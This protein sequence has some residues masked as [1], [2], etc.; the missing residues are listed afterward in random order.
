LLIIKRIE[1]SDTANPKFLAQTDLTRKDYNVLPW[2]NIAMAA[3]NA[4]QVAPGRAE[5]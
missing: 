4:D 2:W 1:R 3:I 5:I